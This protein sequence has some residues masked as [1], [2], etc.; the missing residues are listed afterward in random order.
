MAGHI[1]EDMR[2]L[3]ETDCQISTIAIHSG[4][5]PKKV[6][7]QIQSS[8]LDLLTFRPGDSLKTFEQ[9]RSIH[10]SS[11]FQRSMIAAGFSCLGCA[12]FTMAD[13]TT[14]AVARAVGMSTESCRSRG[15]RQL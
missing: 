2:D 5:A 13:V 4:A 3:A 9:A 1:A 11:A 7:K 8:S 15:T 14:S 12:R 10:F 6:S